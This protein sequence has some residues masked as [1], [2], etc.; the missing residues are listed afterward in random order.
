MSNAALLLLPYS[1]M[2]AQPANWDS[3]GNKLQI[4]SRKHDDSFYI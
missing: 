4:A 1:V 3:V 2:G